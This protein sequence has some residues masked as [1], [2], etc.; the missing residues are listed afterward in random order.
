M[1]RPIEVTVVSGKGGTG[2]TVLVSSLARLMDSKVMADCDVDAPDLHLLLKP[3]ITRKE[4]FTGGGVAAVNAALCTGCGECERRC[5]FD[6]MIGYTGH[7]GVRYRVDPIACE[8]C[9]VCHYACPAG[10]IE[11]R[12]KKNGR[13]FVSKTAFGPFVHACL[14]PAEENSG[15]LVSVVR[16]EARLI[17]NSQGL[18]YIVVDGPPGIGCPVISSIAGAHLVVI[19]TEPTVSGIH[20][21]E[22]VVSLA[23]H[24][25][26]PVAGV[27]NKFDINPGV[28]GETETF[29][30]EKSVALLGKIPFG[31][32]V[33]SCLAAGTLVVD[34]EDSK[35][36]RGLRSVGEALKD[37]LEG[38]A[39][40]AAAS[41][42]GN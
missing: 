9:A 39:S 14:D 38:I 3:E 24:F 11:M 33:G 41:K 40:E 15:K 5:R 21:C 42:L 6:A 7:G 29:F 8:G 13:W 2:K 18:K 17:A 36:A 4:A 1:I 34:Q 35:V 10:A 27:I 26:I 25:G 23:R 22:R 32:E 28:T 12:E 16:K 37:V 31:L 19:V 20:D 30:E